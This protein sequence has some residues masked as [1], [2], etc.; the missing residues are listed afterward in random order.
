MLEGLH[1]KHVVHHVR[2][3][4]RHACHVR[5]HSRHHHAIERLHSLHA[6]YTRA[7]LLL[8]VR[9][10][11]VGV[12]MVHVRV[13]V[14]STAAHSSRPES[15]LLIT[16][17]ERMVSEPTG[18]CCTQTLR[19]HAARVHKKTIRPSETTTLGCAHER[20]KHNNIKRRKEYLDTLS[21]GRRSLWPCAKLHRAAY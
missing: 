1:T 16:E 19:N 3:H 8:H 11:P 12:G 5:H 15:T 17:G 9:H 13:V 6:L 20:T 7:H 21:M 18:T 4:L 2:R 10:V 14:V